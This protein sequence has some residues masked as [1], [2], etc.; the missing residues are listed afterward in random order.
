MLAFLALT[1]VAVLGKEDMTRSLIAALLGLLLAMI[2]VDNVT[3]T[4]RFTLGSDRVH[5]I[6]EE[7]VP[8][9]FL[10]LL[11]ELAKKEMEGE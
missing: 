3:N 10:S 8:D 1:F 9:R 2:G 6:L 7:P 5:E 4:H 11:D